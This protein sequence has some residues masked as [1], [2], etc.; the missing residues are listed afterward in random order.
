[1]LGTTW[2]LPTPQHACRNPDCGYSWH[3]SYVCPR[4]GMSI[5]PEQARARAVWQ[6]EKMRAA[7]AEAEQER[8]VQNFVRNPNDPVPLTCTPSRYG[9]L[10]EAV[11]VVILFALGMLV[12]VLA[13]AH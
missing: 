4:E 12:L 6:L 13:I 7:A 10:W 2:H 11:P 1:M 3:Y 8:R 9:W 5:S